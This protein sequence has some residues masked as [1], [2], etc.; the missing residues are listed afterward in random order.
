[1]DL[2]PWTAPNGYVVDVG[3]RAS[4]ERPFPLPRNAPRGADVRDLPYYDSWVPHPGV[5]LTPAALVQALRQAELGQPWLMVDMLDD[6]VEGDGHTRNVFEHRERVVAKAPVVVNAGDASAE[7][8]TAAT[9]LDQAF[10]QL[11]MKAALEQLLRGGNR[12]GFG[13]IELDWDVVE[14]NGRR[15]ILPVWLTP[16]PARRFRIGTQGMIPVPNYPTGEPTGE[17]QIRIDELRFFMELKTPQ[18]HP[19]RAGKWLTIKRQP[20][21]VARGGLGRT[22]AIYM[23]AKRFSFRDWIVLSQRYG[24]PWPIV[25]VEEEADGETLAKASEIIRRLGSDGGAVVSDK[26]NL[27]I[28][29]GVKAKT[30]MQD[31]LIAFCNGEISKLVNGSTLRNDSRGA[32]SYGLGDVHDNVAWDEVRSDGELLSEALTLQVA[33]AFHR[34]NALTSAPPTVTMMVEPDIGPVEFMSQAIKAKNELGIEV[35]QKQIREKTGLR[36]PIDDADKAPGMQV[37]AFPTGAGGPP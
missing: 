33:A 27:E 9:V 31:S 14:V 7:A 5:G 10:K 37:D 2:G 26:L 17:T 36:A 4:L 28:N 22:A 13:G 25:K 23:M 1:M 21:Q 8:Q 3:R 34:F 24:I 35:S 12:Y 11:P 30:P 32:G 19:L 15:W 16:A 29:D 18:G 20:N 6:L